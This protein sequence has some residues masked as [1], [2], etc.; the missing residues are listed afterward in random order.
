LKP[1]QLLLRPSA[2]RAR[3]GT[4]VELDDLLTFASA[5]FRHERRCNCRLASQAKLGAAEAFSRWPSH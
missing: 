2:F 3:R 4:N 5:C 1:S